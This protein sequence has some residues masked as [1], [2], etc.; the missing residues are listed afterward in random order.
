MASVGRLRV[1][2]RATGR[3]VDHRAWGPSEASRCSGFGRR[4]AAR[5][6]PPPAPRLTATAAPT[7]AHSDLQPRRM[8]V[9]RVVFMSFS[10]PSLT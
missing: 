2:C 7:A 4:G 6:S 10:N 9:S 3:S 8:R 1:V 5:V